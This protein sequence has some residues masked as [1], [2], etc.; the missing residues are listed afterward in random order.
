MYP[1]YKGEIIDT[2]FKVDTHIMNRLSNYICQR[3]L[4]RMEHMC[5]YP[6]TQLKVTPT[7]VYNKL[8]SV[9]LRM[10][11]RAAFTFISSYQLSIPRQ[12]IIAM[13]SSPL[14]YLHHL[15]AKHKYVGRV[16]G[17]GITYPLLRKRWKRVRNRAR[18]HM[19]RLHHI[20]HYLCSLPHIHQLHTYYQMRVLSTTLG[21]T[22]YVM[23]EQSFK[24]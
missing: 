24:G 7:Q 17:T 6:N 4:Y 3:V 2:I 15:A 18:I 19:I 13:N 21:Y 10:K 12:R 16:Q 5:I 9:K 8:S 1:H 23:R 14:N 11:V 22:H 20:H